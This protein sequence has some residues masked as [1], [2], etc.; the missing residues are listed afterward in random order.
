MEQS[1]G[2]EH[3][4]VSATDESSKSMADHSDQGR[5]PASIADIKATGNLIYK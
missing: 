3:G 2:S 4:G 5:E 1:Y